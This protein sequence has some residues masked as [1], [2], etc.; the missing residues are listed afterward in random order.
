MNKAYNSQD[1]IDWAKVTNYR[2]T[3]TYEL[4]AGDTPFANLSKNDKKEIV[5]EQ[6]DNLLVEKYE[7][8]VEPAI[9]TATS[10]LFYNYSNQQ[11]WV[12]DLKTKKRYFAGCMSED[13][14]YSKVEEFRELRKLYE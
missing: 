2:L 10:A 1:P 13:D 7:V 5:S 9:T 6:R 14:F 11:K 12:I 4:I 8:Y 3:Y